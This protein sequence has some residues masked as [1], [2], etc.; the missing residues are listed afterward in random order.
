[1]AWTL[2]SYAARAADA[3]GLTRRWTAPAA[4]ARSSGLSQRGTRAD[5]D[6][7]YAR[8]FSRRLARA[9]APDRKALEAALSVLPRDIVERAVAS[10]APLAAV[11][12]LAARWDTLTP[13]ARDMVVNPLMHDGTGAVAWGSVRAVQV[14]QT[15]C[16]AAVMSMATM[17]S[18]PFTAL[19]VATGATV[20]D[21][22]PPEVLQSEVAHRRSATL[23]ERWQALQR[24][25]HR[26]TTYR[27]M[28][29]FPWP[30]TLG[31]PPWR[32][33]DRLRCAGLK[34]RGV[35]V[36]DGRPAAVLGLLAHATAALRDGIPV[37]AYTSGDS[38]LGLDTVVPRHVILFVGRT[39]DR[40]LAY[41]PGSG[42]VHSV[43]PDVLAHPRGRLAALGQWSRLVW[44]VLPRAR[45]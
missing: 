35:I 6:T 22:V 45:S 14:D 7:V 17:I 2:T 10:G 24:V 1:M 21:Y 20:G 28:G 11:A 26:S 30:R 9:A 25:M 13:L 43:A 37:P 36:D 44:L 34:F 18:D 32:V 12:G 29:P 42:A 8:L 19:W 27:A 16:G 4:V 3:V 15:T 33:D 40:L 39:D 31:T 5:G 41:E 23:E 38:A